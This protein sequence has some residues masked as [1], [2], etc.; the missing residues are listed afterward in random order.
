[1]L[2]RQAAF[3]TRYFA[4]PLAAASQLATDLPLFVR[5]RLPCWI[6]R[7][8]MPEMPEMFDP[9]PIVSRPQI[10]HGTVR[11]PTLRAPSRL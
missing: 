8:E 3:A 1:M 4:E 10:L 2:A 5:R 6:A 11:R 9:L 7:P